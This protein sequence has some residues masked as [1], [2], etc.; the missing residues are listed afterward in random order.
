MSRQDNAPSRARAASS[1]RRAAMVCSQFALDA[2]SSVRR[3]AGALGLACVAVHAAPALAQTPGETVAVLELAAPTALEFTVRGT[4]P[5]PPGIYPR[6]DGLNPF[7]VRSHDN[8]LV[9]AQTEV[10]S[11]YPVRSDGADVVEVI[12]RVRRQAALTPGQFT[13]FDVVYA[14]HVD[15]PV[16]LT[17]RVQS[18]RSL[19]NGIVLRTRDVYGNVYRSD[20]RAGAL[21]RKLLKDGSEL[22][23]ERCY[24]VLRP[25]L[26][27]SGSSGT[28][29]HF[30]GVHS[31]LSYW[32]HDDVV[33]LDLR[34]H[35]G[36][37]GSD[38][39]PG[40]VLDDLQ[41]KLYFDQLELIVPEGWAI[42]P[43][44]DDPSI[45]QPRQLANGR[46]MRPLVKGNADGT[47]H[48]LGRQA[49]FLRRVAIARV[50]SEAYG[51]ELVEE[52][53][54]GYCRFGVNSH[55]NALWSWW[56]PET[57]RYYPQRHKLP[58]LS[59]LGDVSGFTTTRAKLRADFDRLIDFFEAGASM[60]VYPLHYPRLGWAHPWGVG[61]GGMTGGTEIVMYDGFI[62]AFA[63]SNDGYR[64]TLLRH[65]MYTDR[66]N[67]VLFEM[68]GEPT[69]VFRWLVHGSNGV[70]MPGNFYQVQI[71]GPDMLG[72]GSVPTHQV[73]AV[74]QSGL[75]PAYEAT[76][77]TFRPIDLQHLVRYLSSPKALAWLGNDSVAKDDILMQ[78]EL[79]RMSYFHAP[80]GA[81]GA[82][83]GSS[84]LGDLNWV[85][86]NPGKGFS[87]GRGEGW[88]VDAMCAA[89]SLGHPTWR[90]DAR[91]WFERIADMVHDGRVDCTGMIQAIVNTKI[92]N[93]LYRARQS[94]EQ[95]IVENALW[96]MRES[97]FRGVDFARMGKL[98]RVIIDSAYTMIGFPAWE[99]IG[100]G[101][102]NHVAI[103][104]ISLAQPMFCN[105][106]PTEG[107]AA[108][109][110]DK[111]QSWCTLAYGWELSG[112]PLFLQR[113]IQMSGSQYSTF[114]SAVQ[115]GFM[116]ME[117]KAALMSLSNI[118][119]P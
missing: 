113:T 119:Y 29:P 83:L 69:S 9:P 102:W 80:V 8:V 38:R 42:L 52:R 22:L 97:V 111:F 89:Y 86:N 55:G 12:A 32:A 82:A 115:G 34:V 15:T 99:P 44:F 17:P 1:S 6:A 118:V 103:G 60:N 108:G 25:E 105:S 19:T 70:Y 51:Q 57:A 100:A 68:N 88:T 73:N 66:M 77:S 2:L 26:P 91:N 114:K 45:G 53:F 93:G 65:R 104:P 110:L 76:L 27:Q 63:A 28:L 59:Y 20:L 5:V 31:Y 94:I 67:D 78:A 92:L 98:K 112:D 90:A 16:A 106:L 117:N 37:S 41:D 24:D 56:N 48:V 35:N 36:T 101:P 43:D 74:Q 47:L 85:A 14:P 18:L 62:T 39:S 107:A 21:G 109:G 13:R 46:V 87:F 3:L 79:A 71:T 72:W 116:N 96:S 49:Q 33:Q 58:D 84:M 64:Y 95:A 81:N 40:A 10:V 61:Y 50:G 54:L 23:Q 30:M 4:F 75:A 11:S 7:Q